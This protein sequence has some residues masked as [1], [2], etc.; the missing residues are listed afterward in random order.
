MPIMHTRQIVYLAIGQFVLA[1]DMSGVPTNGYKGKNWKI[2]AKHF[3]NDVL[4]AS[5]LPN[6]QR[7][8]YPHDFPL[9]TLHC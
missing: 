6:A 3:A 1:G 8:L 4:R 9:Q 2:D 5:G 7:H